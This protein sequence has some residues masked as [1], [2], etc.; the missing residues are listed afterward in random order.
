MKR[1]QKLIA[2]FLVASFCIFVSPAIFASDLLE[3][4]GKTVEALVYVRNEIN[5]RYQTYL[6]AESSLV[7]LAKD[8]L[9][10]IE[11]KVNTL[12]SQ[13][14]ALDEN[15]RRAN[16][17]LSAVQQDIKGIQ[18]QMAD[19]QELSEMREVE[20]AR[21]KALL[22][23]FIRLA[24]QETMQYTDWETGEISTLKFL[25]QN[26]TLSSAEIK[27]AYLSVLQSTSMGLISDLTSKQEEYNE[28]NTD[29]LV[30]RGQLVLI[31]Q[32]LVDKYTQLKE[33]QSAKQRLLAETSGEER[34]YQQL[35]DQ[36]RRQ[37]AEALF[38][39]EDLQNQLGVVDNQLT[40]LKGQLGEASFEQLLKDQSAAGLSGVTFPGRMPR[41]TWPANPS[42]GI[43]AYFHDSSYE[44]V[45]GVAHQAIDFRLRQ[46]SP[47]GAAAP[48]IVY[49]ARDNGY[50]YSYIMLAHPGGLATVYGHISKI[51]VKEGEAVKAGKI[52]GLSGG[53][54]GTIGAGYMTTGAHLH[55]EVLD[56]GQHVDALDYLPLEQL[57]IGDIP[58][59]YLKYA[60]GLR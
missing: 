9:K 38:E 13:V 37:Q 28:A 33:M 11:A 14:Q 34:A 20:L 46:G 7:D 36:S 49:K 47:V 29:L 15:I 25:L 18:L 51:L 10:P 21:S 44:G 23:E 35:V 31:Q 4:A 27:Q 3:T 56:G 54:P 16:L 57:P 8:K 30:K 22:N 12:R 55:F 58:Q 39:I 1:L 59:R 50:G 53:T 32:E 48:G 60:K 45:F 52:I 17:N 40:S 41:L 24:Y 2:G 42:G 6:N 26:E 43:T 5:N 19:L